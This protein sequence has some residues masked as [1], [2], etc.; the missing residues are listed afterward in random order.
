VLE[1]VLNIAEGRDRKV[2]DDLS[3]CAG[4]SLADRHH[5]AAHHRSVFTLLNEPSALE[6]DVRSLITCAMGVLSLVEHD[7]VHPRFGVVDVVPF[8]AL[9]VAERPVARQLRDATA[10]WIASTFDVAAFL[11]GPLADGTTRSLPEVRRDAFSRLAPDFGPDVPS[12]RLGAVAVGERPVLVAW[13]IWLAN[14]TLERSREIARELR[15]PHVRALG[16]RIGAQVQVS[17]NLLD[18]SERPPST[19]YDRVESMLRDNERVTRAELVGLAPR[20]LLDGEDPRRWVQLD[21][22]PEKTIEA[23]SARGSASL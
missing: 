9:D 3:R 18:V 17:C 14:T 19:V 2:L 4:E 11:Y 20:S 23:A 7:G 8:V 12:P 15:G 21:L 13:N 5:D 6:R 10:R 1:C 16:F 22:S